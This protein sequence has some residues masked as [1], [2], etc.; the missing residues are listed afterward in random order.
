MN[1]KERRIAAAKAGLKQ[2]LTDLVETR[3]EL[4]DIIAPRTFGA[5]K[6]S[7]M[8]DFE[9]EMFGRLNMLEALTATLLAHTAAHI[10]DPMQFTVQV[11]SDVENNLERSHERAAEG[12]A[13]K[14]AHMAVASFQNLG[15]H[16]LAHINRHADPAGRG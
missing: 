1:A 13:K 12:D 5:S 8:D 14:C 16:M 15:R 10:S 9:I 4:P 6:G 11:M 7:K 3:K 2:A